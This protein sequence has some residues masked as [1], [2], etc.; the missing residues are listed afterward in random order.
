MASFLD[1]RIAPLGRSGRPLNASPDCVP[2]GPACVRASQRASYSTTCVR[3]TQLRPNIPA[4]N[5]NTS[6]HLNI[7]RKHAP[8]F[9]IP[10]LLRPIVPP[11]PYY[12]RESHNILHILLG[13]PCSRGTQK[14]IALEIASYILSPSAARSL[15]K[16]TISD[17]TLLMTC[18]YVNTLNCTKFSLTRIYINTSYYHI[19]IQSKML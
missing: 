1:A 11:A 2:I 12:V 5:K 19:Q 10:I 13:N 9:Q 4:S 3:P 15:G 17:K 8:P 18:M 14:G 16:V 7:L 6:Y